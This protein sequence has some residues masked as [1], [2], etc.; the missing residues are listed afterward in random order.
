V[1]RGQQQGLATELPGQLGEGDQR[2]GEGDGADQ[3]AD[4][5]L[6]LVDGL[7]GGGGEHQ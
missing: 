2:S 3:D 7:L 1:T 6:H 4:V 5:D